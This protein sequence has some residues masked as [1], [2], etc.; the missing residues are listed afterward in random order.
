MGFASYYENIC[1]RH[2][3]STPM[4]PIWGRYSGNSSKNRDVGEA[5]Y[6][7]GDAAERCRKVIRAF[8]GLT[9]SAPGERVATRSVG[10][11]LPERPHS[12]RHLTGCWQ[13]GRDQR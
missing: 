9:N 5:S 10:I 6:L 12:S 11:A 3:A 7:S 1:E 13:F 4:T 8:W 2:Y